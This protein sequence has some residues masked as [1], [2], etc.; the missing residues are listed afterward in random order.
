MY[1]RHF[2]LP[3]FPVSFFLFGPR[4]TGKST[5]VDRLLSGKSALKFDFLKTEVALLYKSNPKLF[6][7]HA[8]KF[9]QDQEQPL[10]VIDEVQ[11]VPEIL[12]NVQL[13]MHENKQVQFI[14]TGSSARKLK[15]GGANL[16]GGRAIEYHLYPLTFSE[17]GKNFDLHQI[18]GRGS[19]P[20]IVDLETSLAEQILRT[21]VSIYMKEEIM[22][23]ALV[24]NIVPFN[25]FLEIAADQNGQLTNYTN[26]ASD[27]GIASKT[28]QAYYQ[29]LEDTLVCTRVLPYLRGA[30]RRLNQQSKYYF[31]DTGVTNLLCKHS[32]KPPV[33]ATSLF[34]RLFEHYIFLEFQRLAHYFHDPIS[35]YHWRDS[36]DNEVDLII[37][38][39][40]ELLAIEIKS[41]ESV[42]ARDLKGLFRFGK[43]YPQAKL[44][45]L[46][47]TEH[48]YRLEQVEVHPWKMF[49]EQRYPQIIL[50]SGN[51]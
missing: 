7:S 29:I 35:I 46:S 27:V 49:F 41:R 8:E 1:Q 4:Q 17:L 25:R 26:I 19:L 14:L 28:I 9:I 51:S 48:P 18:L 44:I 16:L 39:A 22:D 34:G 36:N 31:F 42:S 6:R 33:P 10:I 13:L 50:L 11:K 38:G 23:E 21:Y 2:S 3:S 37:E 5:L 32:I 43:D 20:S 12:D 24:R 30:R 15:R 45:C 40:D 47:T